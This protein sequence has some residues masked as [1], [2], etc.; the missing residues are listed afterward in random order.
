MK[1]L[2][3][4]SGN[5]KVNGVNSFINV[6]MESLRAAGV[7]MRLYTVNGHGAIGYLKN[8]PTLRKLIR[9]WQ[10]DI[11]HAHY[12][13]CGYLAA[14]AC[15]G[16]RYRHAEIKKPKVFLSILGSFHWGTEARRR[17]VRFCIHHV[18]DGVLVKAQRTADELNVNVS[19]VPNGINLEQ[20]TIIP[21]EKA[22]KM[23][24]MKDDTKYVMFITNPKW[25]YHKN[26]PL[27]KAAIQLINDDIRWK[28]ENGIGEIELK[29]VFG[30]PHNDVIAYMCG[31]DVV[32]MT[33]NVEGSPNVI[34]EAMACNCPIV[35]TDV[36]DVSWLLDS[37][38]GSYMAWEKTPDC[39]AEAVKK[40]I[41]FN[42][43]TNGREKI[44]Q[45]H[46]TVE[47]VAQQIIEIY[48]SLL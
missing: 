10:P 24:G 34:K 35:S 46:L 23:V 13:I 6:Q 30:V 26:Y 20:F 21:K 33:S 32:L 22:R 29:V 36:G 39:V 31:G 45:L 44:Q 27:A 37:V 11:V 15:I 12:T 43:R 17:L 28:Q 1:V 18:W 8:V 16:I 9:E 14:I 47:E 3:V 4:A 48:K 38:S 5:G 41:V 40:A 42:G 19:V 7:D 25:V 2:F